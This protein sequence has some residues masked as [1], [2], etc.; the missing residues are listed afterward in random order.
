MSSQGKKPKKI[1]MFISITTAGPGAGP[2]E[3]V[4]L[5]GWELMYLF[6]DKQS[7]QFRNKRPY[8]WEA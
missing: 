5:A 2:Y 7:T 6:V 3:S 4:Y 8:E 1:F